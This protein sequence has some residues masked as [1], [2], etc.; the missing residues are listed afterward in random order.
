MIQTYKFSSSYTNK[1]K[2]D[3]IREVGK[4]YKFYYN[5]LIPHVLSK[6][7]KNEGLIPK[8]LPQLNLTD[9]SERY[10]QTCGK[11]VKSNLDSWRSNIKNRIKEKIIG[12]DLPGETKKILI[13][14]N[15]SGAWF[16]KELEIKREPVSSEL[17]KL[18]RKMFKHCRGSYPKLR[19]VTMNLDEKVA[20]VEKPENGLGFDYWIKLAT[21][22]KR[23]PIYLPIKS[24]DYFE[25]RLGLLK[26]Q[27]QVI[28]RPDNIEYGFVKDVEFEK[29]EPGKNRI[30]GI[31]TGVKVPLSTSTGNQYGLSLYGRL[32]KID[33]QIINCVQVRMKNGFYKKSPKLNGLY[34]RARNLLKNEIGRISNEFFKNEKPEEIVLENNKEVTEGLEKFSKQMKRL[35]KGSGITRLRD[36]L[37]QKSEKN[38]VDAV[39]INQAYTSQECPVCH[40]IDKKNRKSQRI[41]KC[42]KCGFTRNADYVASINIRNRRSIARVD[43]YTSYKLIRG[44]IEAYYKNSGPCLVF[45]T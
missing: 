25:N 5:K 11:Q 14:I 40:N 34:N 43:I 24:Y 42:I 7:Y 36:I 19:N 27:I 22:E 35:I 4:S 37:I 9:L 15:S 10:K 17:L 16:K 23:H 31:D 30:I 32:R 1:N 45:Q 26:R 3:I 21:L 12:S 33:D 28:V 2:L 39:K 29:M 8:F 18:S 6:F 13:T 38:G 20:S 41:F 44:L